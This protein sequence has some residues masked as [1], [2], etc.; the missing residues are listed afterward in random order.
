MADPLTITWWWIQWAKELTCKPRWPLNERSKLQWEQY[1]RKEE[2][3]IELLK[4]I[5]GFSFSSP[6]ANL[7]RNFLDELNKCWLYAPD[8]VIKKGYKFLET[9]HKGAESTD[10][11]KKQALGDFVVTIRKDLLS[12][13][14]L[15][16]TQLTSKD[17]K[18]LK[19]I[20]K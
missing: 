18:P 15:S 8:Q 5:P 2:S 4:S 7:R 13:K 9:V 3:Y 17:F 20:G 19:P 10:E 16:E 11:E 1:K 14:V 12:R 6:D